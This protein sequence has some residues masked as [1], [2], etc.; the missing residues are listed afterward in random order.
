MVYI[1]HSFLMHSSAD[2][3]LGCFYVLAVINR[4]KALFISWLQ[5]Q[6]TVIWEP[7]KMKS[8][9]VGIFIPIYL[10]WD[11]IIISGI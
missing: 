5:S 10:P 7:K 9:T 3:H 6:S 1:Y 2:G 4:S 11:W 8:V